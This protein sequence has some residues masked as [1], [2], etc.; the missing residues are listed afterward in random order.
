MFDATHATEA[1][2]AEAATAREVTFKQKTLKSAIGCSGVGLHSGKKISMTLKPAPIG[3][4]IVFHR[5]DAAPGRNPDIPAR[6]DAVVD[7]RLCTCVGNDAGL[8]VGTI[9]HLMSAL[10]GMGIDNLIIDIDGPEVPVM[11]GSAAPFVFL[12]ECAGTAEQAAPRRAIKVLEAVSVTDGG[13]LARLDPAESDFSVSFEIAFSNPLIGRQTLDI[14]F[15]VADAAAG[16]YRAEVSSA[17]TFGF[18]E[19]V[20]RLNKM[21]LALGGSLDNAVVISGN[22]VL[23]EEGLRFDDECVRH[24]ALDAVGDLYLAGAP[25]IGRFSGS[26]SGHAHSNQLLRALFANPAAWAFVEIDDYALAHQSGWRR[27]AVSA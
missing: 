13:I 11:D 15:P 1:L 7:T 2:P 5:T 25:I 22:K 21:G 6:Y 16:P 4:G 24:K 12:I 17:R 19:D 3:N 18:L 20:E 14:T 8:S 9:E 27:E 23:N 10:A 26:K